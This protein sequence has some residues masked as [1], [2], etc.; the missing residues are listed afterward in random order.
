[1]LP[2]YLN[3]DINHFKVLVLR[4]KEALPKHYIDKSMIELKV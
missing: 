2:L 4:K 1:V 3:Q